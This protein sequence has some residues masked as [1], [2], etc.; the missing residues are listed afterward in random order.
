[1]NA[2]SSAND[3]G[4]HHHRKKMNPIQAKVTP[5]P[6]RRILLMRRDGTLSDVATVNDQRS[7]SL[8]RGRLREDVPDVLLHATEAVIRFILKQDPYN[9]LH[10][11]DAPQ[12]LGTYGGITLTYLGVLRKSRSC[13]AWLVQQASERGLRYSA[14]LDITTK[15]VGEHF[16]N[17]CGENLKPEILKGV[18]R[19]LASL[20]FCAYAPARVRRWGVSKQDTLRGAICQVQAKQ[21]ELREQMRQ[22]EAEIL[23]ATSVLAKVLQE[24][25]GMP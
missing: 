21:N 20:K 17:N 9:I 23:E 12:D 18:A 19:A 7:W 25:F 11:P 13:T 3:G 22:N 15:H 14:Y 5:A 4:Q 6:L 2:H 8:S 1:M 16:A 10:T 24:D